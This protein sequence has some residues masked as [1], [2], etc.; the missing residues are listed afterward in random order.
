MSLVADYFRGLIE[1]VQNALNDLGSSFQTYRSNS[2]AVDDLVQK[3]I[4]VAQ[5]IANYIL[6]GKNTS[7]TSPDIEFGER[8][9]DLTLCADL[10]GNYTI[11]TAGF[12]MF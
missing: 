8:K 11:S 7:N 3:V 10:H 1:P 4:R 5:P 12:L 6:Q 9:Y 2:A